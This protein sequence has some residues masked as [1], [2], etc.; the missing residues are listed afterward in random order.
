MLSI[1]TP[2]LNGSAF[3]EDNIK[4][5]QRLGV[6]HEHIVVDGHSTDNTLAILAQY[7]TVKVIMQ[8][9][10][11]EMYGAIHEGILAAQGDFVCYLNCD[12]R[13]LPAGFE[14][15][16]HAAISSDA[17]LVYGDGVF[18]YTSSNQY[19]YIAAKPWAAYWLQH[20]ELPFCQPSSIFKKIVYKK[21]GGF[22]YET[23]KIIGDF[24]LFMRIATLP[25]VKIK[26]LNVPATVFLKHGASFGDLNT[27]RYLQEKQVIMAQTNTSAVIRWA[28]RL[29][30][31]ISN[32]FWGAIN[33]TTIL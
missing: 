24:D 22:H 28:F 18:F 6:K 8:S 14:K 25:C 17:D 4:S 12:D 21:I 27:N 32:Q 1:I 9:S 5:V 7:P 30:N 3:I 31:F 19:K 10:T 11:E 15:L 23:F 2:V 13:L 29:V 20:G 16:Y 33:R 26:R